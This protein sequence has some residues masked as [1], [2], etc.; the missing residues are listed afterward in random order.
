[1]LKS[2]NDLCELLENDNPKSSKLVDTSNLQLFNKSIQLKGVSF[3][4]PNSEGLTFR[5]VNFETN[6]GDRIG[7]L[8]KTGSGKSTLLDIILGLLHP[9]SGTVLCDGVDRS[10]IKQTDWFRIFFHVPQSI[11]L[12]DMTISENIA[13]FGDNSLINKTRVIEMAELAHIRDEIEGFSDGF[14]TIVG[15]RGV[16]LSGGQL[17]RIGIARALYR[18]AQIIILDEATSA[19]DTKIEEKIEN[20]LKNMS[21]DLTIIKVAHRLNT[22][23]GCNK[24]SV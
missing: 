12:A 19:V 14:D 17:Q 7:I 13:G 9:C 5:N 11:Y 10:L 23:R 3:S 16:R 20:S 4:Y 8:G 18:C 21:K 22:L 2:L 6:P 24:I 15:E 1:M